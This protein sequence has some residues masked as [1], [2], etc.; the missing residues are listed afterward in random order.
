ML[1]L[2]T[3]GASVAYG[4]HIS[5][6]SPI[7]MAHT[8]R[9][10]A[11]ARARPSMDFTREHEY[12]KTDRSLSLSDVSDPFV[13]EHMLSRRR[14]HRAN[15]RPR[16]NFR[17][18]LNLPTLLIHVIPICVTF[19][20]F[21][22]SYPPTAQITDAPPPQFMLISHPCLQRRTSTLLPWVSQAE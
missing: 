6:A 8:C 12:P 17:W 13:I 1:K 14:S 3:A 4:H 22:H 7:P 11:L 15:A 20:L 18:P 21:I 2:G 5:L 16:W 9:P 10:P 19:T